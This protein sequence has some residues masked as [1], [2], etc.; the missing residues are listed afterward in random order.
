MRIH[1][2]FL[3]M[4]H[5]NAAPVLEAISGFVERITFH[6]IEN[7]YCV[8]RVNVRGHRELVTVVGY[9]HSIAAGEFLQASGTWVNSKGYGPQ[10]KAEFLKVSPPTTEEGIEK[11]LASG[12]V[13]GIG[14][15]YAKK[16][17]LAFGVDVFEVIEFTPEKLQTL[18]GIGSHRSSLIVKGW[19]D[20]K[21][22]REI[23]L[24]LHQYGVSTA[25]AVR[26]YKTFGEN[27]I[28]VM[29]E[30]PYRLARDVRGIGFL[31]AD[32]IAL[33]I[34]IEKDSLMRAQAGLNHVLFESTNQGHC[35]LPIKDLLAKAQTLLEIPQEILDQALECELETGDL[36]QDT[37][38][39][40]VCI[41]LKYL[42]HSEQ[43]IARLLK[44]TALGVLPWGEIKGDKEI[45]WV[46]N[47]LSLTLSQSQRDAVHKALCSKVLTITGGPGVG[48]TTLVKSL[49]SILAAQGIKITLCAPTGRAAKRLSECTG[50]EAKTIHRL[51][52]ADPGTGK[53]KRG[54]DCLLPCQLLI[55]D[56]VSMID[57]SLMLALLKALPQDSALFLIGDVDQLPSVGPGNVLSNIIYASSLPVARLTEIFRQA[58]SSKIILNAHRINKGL[59]PTSPQKQE[60]S[61]FYFIET[62]DPE[63]ATHR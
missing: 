12:M 34:G 10:F 58:S 24:F 29:T 9:S 56:E 26:I 54:V 27:S 37:I 19:A 55:V 14:P 13:K 59:M 47:Q 18:D 5:S 8:L 42:Y 22:V 45:A 53:F 50:K 36:I 32:Q 28:Q 11:Y 25:R 46:E 62:E 44:N 20:Q 51:L 57:V 41:F 49:M 21:V 1:G 3:S 17:V 38:E 16:L 33:R 2:I 48:K 39:N 4:N 63:N 35:A 60:D 40:E 52:E 31:S 43:A 7:G 15:V 61:D 30:N 6:N 23:M